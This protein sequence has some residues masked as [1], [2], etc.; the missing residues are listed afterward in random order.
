MCLLFSY[1]NG[2][3]ELALKEYLERRYPELSCS[4][5]HQVCP[6]WRE[7]ER[8]STTIADAFIKPVTAKYIDGLNQ[9][10]AELELQAPWCLMKSNGGSMLSESA[11]EQPVQTLLS[12]LASGVIGGNYFGE[13]VGHSNLFTLDMD[14]AGYMPPAAPIVHDRKVWIF[15]GAFQGS[16]SLEINPN[17]LGRLG[18]PKQTSAALATIPVDRYVGLMAGSRPGPDVS[19]IEITGLCLPS[20][21]R[22][23]GI[24]S[25]RPSC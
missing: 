2:E 10:F 5:S 1:L 6:M 24:G 25:P 9:E 21:F 3:H 19:R 23:S 20:V 8:T 17:P 16:H 15:Y 22:E 11:A 7:F 4:L 18:R 13:L 14:A 12:G